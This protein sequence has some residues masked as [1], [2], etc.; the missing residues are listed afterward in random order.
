M[1]VEEC[2]VFVLEIRVF[3]VKWIEVRSKV[4]TRDVFGVCGYFGFIR[5]GVASWG[6]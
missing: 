5:V 4:F 1:K 6:V 2:F 3:I